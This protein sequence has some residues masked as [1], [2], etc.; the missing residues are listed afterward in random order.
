MPYI[1]RLEIF[2][3][4]SGKAMA[5]SCFNLCFRF[6]EGEAAFHMFCCDWGFPSGNYLLLTLQAGPLIPH[7]LVA[8]KSFLRGR[9]HEQV[10]ASSYTVGLCA[11]GHSG[12]GILGIWRALAD[13]LVQ[14][15]CWFSHFDE[16]KDS[17]FLQGIPAPT[18]EESFLVTIFP[19]FT[20]CL[21]VL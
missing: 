12:K 19:N 18:V 3:P 16:E 5:C 7:L 11:D 10:I 15:F 21:D 14:L 1:V 9:F 4:S 13:L 20:S 2:C 17:W 8:K 6:L